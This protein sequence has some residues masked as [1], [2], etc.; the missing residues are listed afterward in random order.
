MSNHHLQNR[1]LS[2]RAKGLL[3]LRLSL[4]YDWEYSKK[5]KML[6]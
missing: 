2:L 1:E 3:S 6:R 5:D 4:P